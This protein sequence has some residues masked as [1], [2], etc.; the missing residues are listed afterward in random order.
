MKLG[1]I[2]DIAASGLAAQRARLAVTASNL[3]NSET[4][5]TESGGP[6]RRRD[7]IF[8]SEGTSRPFSAPLERAMRQVTVER[9]AVDDADPL[10]RFDPGHPD[11]DERGFVE[12]P[13]VNVVHEMSN[14]LSASRSYEANLVI[15]RKVREIADAA[16]RI[17]R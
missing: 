15:L 3:A 13:N 8:R 16:L 2:T 1:D 17:G 6:Y 4:T 5:R 9:I 14:L 10:S 11:A 12:M 7:P